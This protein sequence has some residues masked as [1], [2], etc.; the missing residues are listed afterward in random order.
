[1]PTGYKKTQQEALAEFRK[2][3]GNRYDY[4]RVIYKNNSSKV[5]II[6]PVHGEFEQVPGSHIKGHGCR[7]CSNCSPK[8]TLGDLIRDFR[9]THGNLYDYSKVK[10]AKSSQKV[11]ITCKIHGD[12]TQRVNSHKGGKGCARCATE[13]N[14]TLS[15]EYKSIIRETE[16]R[17]NFIETKNREQKQLKKACGNK[18]CEFRGKEQPL[19][20]FHFDR[21]K[22]DGR[23]SNCKTCATKRTRLWAKNNPEKVK[24]KQGAQDQARA[25]A[26][27]GARRHMKKELMLKH[28]VSSRVRGAIKK[29][30]G[31]KGGKTFEALPYTPQELR[32]HIENQF[33]EKMNWDNHGD[34]WHIDHIIPQAALPYKSLE[35]ENFQKCWDLKNLRPL[36]AKENIRKGSLYEGE[37]HTY[38][39]K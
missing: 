17:N 34:Y 31:H 6:C 20:N 27:V 38:A 13:K 21:S 8:G 16:K 10:L 26:R 18:N 5:K 39:N 29:T 23:C 24:K 14:S 11:I 7:K 37:R 12:F 1:M 15:E 28:N 9:K 2:V 4:S 33:D 36:E 30:G 22:K 35:D 25:T 3:H 19:T 32:E